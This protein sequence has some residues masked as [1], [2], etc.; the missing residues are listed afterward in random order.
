MDWHPIQ[1]GVQILLVLIQI[2]QQQQQQQQQPQ[3]TTTT[4]KYFISP[5]G[6]YNIYTN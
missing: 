1:G 5:H 6:Y 2:Q 3:T 4:T